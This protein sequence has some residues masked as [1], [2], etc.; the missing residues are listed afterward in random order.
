MSISF[1]QPDALRQL[2]NLDDAAIDCLDFGVIGIDKDCLVRRYN[3]YESRAAALAP[4]KT[5][6]HDFFTTVAQCMNNYLVAQR[7]ADALANGTPLDATIEYMLT[8]R[9]LPTKA[10]LRLLSAPEYQ[11]RYVLLRRLT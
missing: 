7:F 5:L 2:E 11:T 8:W 9:M 1:D 3:A 4:A 6:G 10:E